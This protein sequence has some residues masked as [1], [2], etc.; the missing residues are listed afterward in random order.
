MEYNIS[1]DRVATTR[2]EGKTMTYIIKTQD[3]VVIRKTA[4]KPYTEAIIARDKNQQVIFAKKMTT[5]PKHSNKMVVDITKTTD[6]GTLHLIEKNNATTRYERV[7][8]EEIG[9]GR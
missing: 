5:N 7:I 1:V 3:G 2:Q 4:T 6:C 8:A 9:G